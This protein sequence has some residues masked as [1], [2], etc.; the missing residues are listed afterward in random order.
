MALQL[1]QKVYNQPVIADGPTLAK[2]P[3]LTST[4]LTLWFR[5]AVRNRN[6]RLIDAAEAKRTFLHHFCTYSLSSEI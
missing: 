3:A 4:A 5:D 2:A 1:L 6:H